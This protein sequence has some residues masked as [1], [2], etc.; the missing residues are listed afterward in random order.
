MT[1]HNLSIIIHIHSTYDIPKMC[2]LAFL[3][4]DIHQYKPRLEDELDNN[5][6]KIILEEYEKYKEY[7]EKSGIFSTYL[8][9]RKMRRKFEED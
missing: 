4:N 1:K 5:A 8:E 2:H 9:C 6:K 3:L 7:R